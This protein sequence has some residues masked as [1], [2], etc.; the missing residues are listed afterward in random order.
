MV[1]N[2]DE[3]Y[4][5]HDPGFM[6]LMKNDSRYGIAILFCLMIM[7]KSLSIR[8]MWSLMSYK[9]SASAK[10]QNISDSSIP[11]DLLNEYSRQSSDP[12]EVSSIQKIYEAD[13]LK[14]RYI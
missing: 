11:K 14:I 12:K 6:A 1:S 10:L 9:N 4:Y 7:R 2:H 8:N 5:N 13:I 3:R